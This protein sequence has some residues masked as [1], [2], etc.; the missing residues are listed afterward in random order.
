GPVQQ[1]AAGGGP[2]RPAQ[3]AG[4]RRGAR[5]PGGLLGAAGRAAPAAAGGAGAALLR[6]PA[7]R[8]DRPGAGLRG[9]HRPVERGPGAGP[10]ARRRAAAGRG[11]AA[12][13]ELTDQA[14][15]DLE[16]LLR[17]TFQPRR[18]LVC[19]RPERLANLVLIRRAR[20]RT[21]RRVALALTAGVLALVGLGIPAL[22]VLGGQMNDNT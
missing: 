21:S 22:R 4:R 20:R 17:A 7:G 5:G 11:G 9:Q 16:D 1:R 13:D 14:D 12:V 10:A 15:G 6:G 18:S 2:G 8:G 3:R 19:T